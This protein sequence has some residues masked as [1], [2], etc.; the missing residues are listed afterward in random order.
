VLREYQIGLIY[1]ALG[2]RENT[3]AW[4]PRGFEEQ[5]PKDDFSESQTEVE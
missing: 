1:N 4:L 5:D 3:Y 2:G